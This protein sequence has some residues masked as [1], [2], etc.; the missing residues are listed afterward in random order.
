MIF[1]K[2]QKWYTMIKIQMI[3]SRKTKRMLIKLNEGWEQCVLTTKKITET[4][5]MV[6]NNRIRFFNIFN[7]I[8]TAPLSCFFFL[9]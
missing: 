7:Q 6:Q 1:K 3:K 4:V 9:L 5:S 8:E 2:K